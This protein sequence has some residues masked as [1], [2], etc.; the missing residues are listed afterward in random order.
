VKNICIDIVYFIYPQVT[1]NCS[2]YEI[3]ENVLEN[4]HGG[5]TG[6]IDR[7]SK[8]E[9]VLYLYAKLFKTFPV[10]VFQPEEDVMGTSWSTDNLKQAAMKLSHD[11]GLAVIV[12]QSP[13]TSGKTNDNMA[14]VYKEITINPMERSALEGMVEL[15]ELVCFLRAHHLADGVWEVLGGSPGHYTALSEFFTRLQGERQ[16]TENQL[17]EAVRDQIFFVLQQAY[18][19]G[20]AKA[21][22]R[23]EMILELF[24][25]KF[26]SNAAE[27]EE[28]KNKDKI[29]VWKLK[30]RYGL[31]VRFPSK[32]FVQE[33]DCSEDKEERSYVRLATTAVHYLIKNQ[34]QTIQQLKAC[35]HKLFP[36][37]R[38][39][40]AEAEGCGE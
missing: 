25:K 36:Q 30:S 38:K 33:D 18:Q 14:G 7:E 21:D 1:S 26:K 8:A 23:D 32:L 9:W 40:R 39:S 34:I 35:K 27:G 29:S 19:Q 13:A 22:K 15:Q 17:M 37:L 24:Y 4:I 31:E 11:F 16:F 12:E 3:R 10:V 20:I 5:Y 28:F 2:K 6:F